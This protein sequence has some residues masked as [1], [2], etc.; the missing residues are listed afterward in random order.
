M[1]AGCY[2]ENDMNVHYI[3]V[4]YKELHM[5]TTV[6]VFCTKLL[7]IRRQPFLK[8]CFHGNIVSL[9]LKTVLWNNAFGFKMCMGSN[10]QL[11]GLQHRLSTMS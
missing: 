2:R 10:A 7:L 5:H 3:S 8:T 9:Q 6:I 1:A 11:Y 4:C